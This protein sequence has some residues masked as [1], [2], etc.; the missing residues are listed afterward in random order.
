MLH[1][2]DQ[3][4]VALVE[5]GEFVHRTG[6]RRAVPLILRGVVD[7]GHQGGRMHVQTLADRRTADA[8]PQQQ[9]R[10]FQAAPGGHHR[11]RL[12]HDAGGLP[13]GGIGV[14]ALDAG[15]CAV[16]DENLLD[17]GVRHDRRARV[18]GVLQIGEHRALLGAG[19]IAHPGVTGQC[20]VVPVAVDVQ[21]RCPV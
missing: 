13:G 12:D 15:G 4:A 5:F 14:G 6:H 21:R 19:V 11:R 7:T 1:T 8:G 16:L 10:G 2:L 3:V 20:R 9:S 18:A 17:P